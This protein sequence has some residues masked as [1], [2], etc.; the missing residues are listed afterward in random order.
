[1]FFR[2]I[3]SS[4]SRKGQST[5]LHHDHKFCFLV[6]VRWMDLLYERRT[7][8]KKAVEIVDRATR[9]RLPQM[10]FAMKQVLVPFAVRPPDTE[11]ISMAAKV[12][13]NLSGTSEAGARGHGGKPTPGIPEADACGHG[14]EPPCNGA[15]LQRAPRHNETAQQRK[16]RYK[17][18][19][20]QRQ[21]RYN[22]NRKARRAF[23]RVQTWL[24]QQ[25][26]KVHGIPA[27]Y[28]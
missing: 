21:A 12:L 14:G 27:V 17:V 16:A 1:M 11:T 28:H 15:A 25:W 7:M 8:V 9:A 22:A 3:F 20:K 19:A 4:R 13:L 6:W 5:T 18:N 10:C 24:R 2:T 26:I 23:W